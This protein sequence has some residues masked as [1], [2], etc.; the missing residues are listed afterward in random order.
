MDFIFNEQ[1]EMLRNMARDFG[2]KECPAK[3]VKELEADGDG[4]SKE[5]WKKM[6]GLGWM[7]LTIPEEYGGMSTEFMDIVVLFEEIGRACIPG[8]FFVTA[9]LGGAAVCIAGDDDQK[10]AI[11]PEIANGNMVITL[12]IDE[13]GTSNGL[14]SVSMKAELTDGYY[15]INGTKLFVPYAAVAHKMILAALTGK[16]LSLFLVDIDTPGIEITPM[17]TI[18]GEKQYEVTFSDVRIPDTALLGKPGE[19]VGIMAQIMPRAKLAKCAEIVGMSQKALE[20]TVDYAKQ[21]VQ[22]DKPIGTLQ[23]IQSY[24]AKMFTDVE[25][26]KLITYKAAWAIDSGLPCDKEVAIAKGWTSGAGRRVAAQA[27]QIHGATGFTADHDLGLYYKRLK[28]AEL[29]FGDE[30]YHKEELAKEI[31]LV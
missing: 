2:E 5:L 29:I 7:E 21:R 14:S 16:E 13:P 30:E 9:M 8:P 19:A 20:M 6:S 22:F 3:L 12:A 10:K 15:T 25:T 26:S 23:I 11:L 1:Q 4:F 24:C 31:G 27:H 18:T 17:P 28:G